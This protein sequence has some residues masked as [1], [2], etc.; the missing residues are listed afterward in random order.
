MIAMSN[1]ADLPDEISDSTGAVS[2]E[3]TPIQPPNSAITVER[4]PDGLTITVPPAGLWRGTAG[5]FP[6]AIIWNGFMTLFTPL[7]LAGVIGG[8][9]RDRGAI[10]MISAFL[11]VFWL[12][13]I[14]LLL[15]ALNMGR[16]R[17]AIAVTAGR[18]MVIQTGLFGTK[19]REWAGT[20]IKKI[21]AGP[22]GMEVN[23]KPI[24]E[25]QIFSESPARFGLLCGRS[26]DEL[27]WI[28]SEL[29]AALGVPGA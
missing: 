23:D 16:R 1:A 3:T 11:S 8:K 17:A 14:G 26:D 18:L 20:E 22:S 19:Q 2:A 25:L 12:V 29:R 4:F 13:G 24:L 5:L 15:G 7:F 28:A 9:E 6:F 10:L 27:R 21:C